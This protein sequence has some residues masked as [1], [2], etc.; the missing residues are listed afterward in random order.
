MP[1]QNSHPDSPQAATF[2]R[3]L[4]ERHG[5][6]KHRHASFIGEFF[7]LSRAAA[8]QRVNR[9]TGWTVDDF[10]ALAHR[11][12]ETLAQVLDDG[13]TATSSD[14]G[15]AAVLRIGALEMGCRM[16]L[17]DTHGTTKESALVALEASGSYVVMP[18]T[19][20]LGLTTVPVARI[21]MSGMRQA[22]TR[23]A[24]LDPDATSARATCTALRDSGID[25]VAYLTVDELLRDIPHAL[26]H[27]YVVDWYL[28]GQTAVAV[29]SAVRGQPRKT[30]VVLL[31]DRTRG[32]SVDAADIAAAMSAFR[33][34]LLE[35]PVLAPTLVSAL[36][37][38]GLV[39]ASPKR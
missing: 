39:P 6:P 9:S 37:N 26:F 36:I 11:F 18:A 24:V 21:E 2:I 25:A 30:A 33:V 27:G 17:A 12:G 20:A 29:L 34:Q 28:P 14:P 23:V 15:I 3:A 38:D 7:G 35:K 16:W 31:S 13:G 8:Y 1:P 10:Q 22:T 5:I 4:L 32:R 19:A